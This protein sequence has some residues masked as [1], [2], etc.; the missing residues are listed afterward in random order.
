M[1]SLVIGVVRKSRGRG[2]CYFRLM[3]RE[4]PLM[5]SMPEEIGEG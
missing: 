3:G 1:Y 5:G 2:G 4:T